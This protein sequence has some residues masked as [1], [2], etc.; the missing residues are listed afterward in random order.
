M[1]THSIAE[2]RPAGAS[3]SLRALL[4]APARALAAWWRAA[5]EREQFAALDARTLRDIGM[6][7]SEYDSYMAEAQGRAE[8]TRLNLPRSFGSRQAGPRAGTGSPR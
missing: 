6:S 1:N 4:A 2:S 3:S 7:R 5:R 8:L